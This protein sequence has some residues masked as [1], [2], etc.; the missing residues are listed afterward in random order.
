MTHRWQPK[1]VREGESVGEV[2]I[3][4]ID[5]GKGW[6]PELSLDDAQQVEAVQEALR[7]G[8]LTA[9]NQLSQ[10][11]PSHPRQPPQVKRSGLQR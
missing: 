9:A 6:S 3:E 7:R 2:E 4:G 11:V 1:L 10:M 5:T 8:D